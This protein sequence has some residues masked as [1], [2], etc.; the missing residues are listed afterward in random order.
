ME[1]TGF[2]KLSQKAFHSDRDQPVDRRLGAANKEKSFL[3]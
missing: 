1:V 3:K 2:Q